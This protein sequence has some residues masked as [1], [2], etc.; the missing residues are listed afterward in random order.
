MDNVISEY[1]IG[2]QEQGYVL[3]LKTDYEQWQAMRAETREFLGDL[4]SGR[5]YVPP[6]Q[7]AWWD[8]LTRLVNRIDAEGGD[9]G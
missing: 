1:V 6:K 2:T 5:T 7:R 3:I 8:R 4:L 9:D